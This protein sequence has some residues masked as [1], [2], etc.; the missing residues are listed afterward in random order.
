MNKANALEIEMQKKKSTTSSFAK[1]QHIACASSFVL[2]CLSYTEHNTQLGGTT[3][4]TTLRF[5]AAGT[6]AFTLTFRCFFFETCNFF[7]L[8]LTIVALKRLFR[9]DNVCDRHGA[10]VTMGSDD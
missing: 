8:L 5:A 7:L 2:L 1:S 6:S 9:S 10:Q 3:A 4:G